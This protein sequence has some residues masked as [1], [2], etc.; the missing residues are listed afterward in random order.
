MLIKMTLIESIVF[1]ID[2]EI[3]DYP[4][5]VIGSQRCDLFT[6]NIQATISAA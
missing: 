4:C 6:N 2:F 5:I 3:T 1:L